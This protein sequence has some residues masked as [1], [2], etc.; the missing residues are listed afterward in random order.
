MTYECHT[1][2][3]HCH[4]THPVPSS[5]R[6]A[7][8]VL[9]LFRGVC[10]DWLEP[11]A[12]RLLLLFQPSRL[13]GPW[14]GWAAVSQR[15]P[16]SLS[17]LPLTPT[18]RG[19]PADLFHSWQRPS[20]PGSPLFLK[21]SAGPDGTR[22]DGRFGWGRDANS[23]FEIWGLASVFWRAS[24]VLSRVTSNDRVAVHFSEPSDL[25]SGIYS[26]VF[27]VL[28]DRKLS[29]CTLWSC[30]TVQNNFRTLTKHSTGFVTFWA[31][32]YGECHLT[33]TLASPRVNVGNVSNAI[34]NERIWMNGVF[35][36]LCSLIRYLCSKLSRKANIKAKLIKY[37]HWMFQV[38][39]YFFTHEHFM[40]CVFSI[41][42]QLGLQ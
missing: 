7:S 3:A 13:E 38:I 31:H 36:G 23:E 27:S 15:S 22:K 19:D 4:C 14:A 42:E 24:T 5:L 11:E 17:G 16:A 9:H 30:Q 8:A 20:S 2:L 40:S 6:K 21:S 18:A 26:V 10:W 12:E 25:K 33:S 29:D 39:F 37:I 32:W 34:E 41:S 1:S 35:Q 28:Y